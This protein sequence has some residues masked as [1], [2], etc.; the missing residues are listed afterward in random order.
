M[1]TLANNQLLS[2][3]QHHFFSRGNNHAIFLKTITTLFFSNRIHQY[4]GKNKFTL[5]MSKIIFNGN[6]STARQ[7]PFYIFKRSKRLKA[8]KK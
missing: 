1:G 5:N 6:E 3:A 8:F 2:N 7:V 4:T